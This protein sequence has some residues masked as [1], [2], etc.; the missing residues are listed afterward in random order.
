MANLTQAVC[1]QG[2]QDSAVVHVQVSL[3]DANTLEFVVAFL[4]V[5]LAR[6]TAAPLNA[7]YSQVPTPAVR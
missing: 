5:T 1:R 4:G 3:V 7:S 2:T 6:A